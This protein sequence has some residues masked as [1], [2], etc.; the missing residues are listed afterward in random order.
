MSGSKGSQ[1]AG[2]VVSGL[3]ALLLC[4]PSAMGKFFDFEGKEEIF[5]K[6]GFSLE[7]MFWIGIVEVVCAVLYLIPWTAFLGA[8]LLTG[9]L[10]GATV[11]HVRIEEAFF[12]P[13]LIGVVMWVGL[14]LRQPGIFSLAFGSFRRHDAVERS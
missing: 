1:I 8:I 10:G 13:I 2:W 12:M 6:F 9:Y 5:E 4:G 11:T 14:A 3:V 7:L